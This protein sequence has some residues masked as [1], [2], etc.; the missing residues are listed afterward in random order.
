MSKNIS[1]TCIITFLSVLL[2]CS[3]MTTVP[4]HNMHENNENDQLIYTFNSNKDKALIYIDGSGLNSVLGV[5]NSDKWISVQFSYF[6]ASNLNRDFTLVIPEKLNFKKGIDYKNDDEA[7]RKYT[8]GNLVESYSRKIDYYI[9]NNSNINEIYLLGI[10]EGGLLAPKIINAIQNKSRIKKMIIWGAGGYSQ[11]EC[12]NILAAS[13]I[14]M[15]ETYR[16]ECKKI[17]EVEKDIELN[18]TAIN[19]YYLGWPYSRW[20]S[21][22][23]YRP[24][25]EYAEIDIPVLFIQGLKD[26]NSPF[27]SVKFVEEEYSKKD[28]EYVYYNDMG[29]IPEKKEEIAKIIESIYSWIKK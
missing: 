24:I 16:N 3:C 29:H 1:N 13:T 22:F 6:L 15:P 8:V 25:N 12:F 4:Y 21:F 26:Y 20:N 9:E 28:Y 23:K 2:L 14:Q 5:I 27:E 11:E 17:S 19:K 18:P 7:L 10:S